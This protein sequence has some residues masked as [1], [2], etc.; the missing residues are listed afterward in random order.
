MALECPRCKVGAL[1]EI[2]LG[3]VLIDRCDTCAGLW[4]DHGEVAELVGQDELAQK[5]EASLPPDE[6]AE[7]SMICPRCAGVALRRYEEDVDDRALVVWRCVSCAGTWIDRGE[8]R[9]FED[10]RV[11]D[12]LAAYLRR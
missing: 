12:A 11:P 6:D 5:I 4:F 1:E 8:L 10:S 2:E 9:G 3:D 7:H